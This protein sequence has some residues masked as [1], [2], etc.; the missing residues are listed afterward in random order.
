MLSDFSREPR[1]LPWQPKLG[2]NKPKL[3]RF[4]CCKR[5][6]NNVCV[7]GRVFGVDEFKYA[8]YNF[9]GGNGVAMATK[10]REKSAKIALI[11][12]LCKISRNFPCEQ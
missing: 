10:F 5:Y 11:L 2:K 3:H 6:G 8:V 12:V 1:E 9:K 4:L 7:Y